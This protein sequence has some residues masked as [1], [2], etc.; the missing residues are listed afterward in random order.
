MV[1]IQNFQSSQMQSQ[2]Q[3]QF[4]V[5]FNERLVNYCKTLSKNLLLIFEKFTQLFNSLNLINKFD[6]LI[7]F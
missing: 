5:D 7:F 3:S 4:Q 6:Y 1:S 2:M